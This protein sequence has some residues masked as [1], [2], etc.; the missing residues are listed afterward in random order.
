MVREYTRWDYELRYPR[1][2][3]EAVDRALAVATSEPAGPV[4]LSL[5]GATRRTCGA[6]G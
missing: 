1:Q 3:N 2:V 6:R 4:Y 5:P